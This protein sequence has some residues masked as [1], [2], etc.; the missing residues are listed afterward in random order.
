MGNWSVSPPRNVHRSFTIVGI[1]IHNW[2][3]TGPNQFVHD[4]YLL[5]LVFLSLLSDFLNE[6]NVAFTEGNYD[7]AHFVQTDWFP[8][9]DSWQSIDVDIHFTSV[10]QTRRTGITASKSNTNATVSGHWFIHHKDVT[11]IPCG[12]HK[13]FPSR[14]VHV[15]HLHHT[16]DMYRH[17]LLIKVTSERVFRKS[18][19]GYSRAMLPIIYL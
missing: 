19:A 10:I 3:H 8:W 15:C 5:L 6:C 9:L 11:S 16:N 1:E 17:I 18:L 12:I 14:Q 2:K 13:R 7:R 4:V